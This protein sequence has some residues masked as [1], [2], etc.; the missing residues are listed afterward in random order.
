MTL[1]AAASWP[2]S[3]TRMAASS[4]C[5]RTDECRPLAPVLSAVAIP[6]IGSPTK[7]MSGWPVPR[8][9]VRRIGAQSFEWDRQRG[10]WPRR[11]TARPAGTWPPPG[12]SAGAGPHPRRVHDRGRSRGPGDRRAAAAAGDR[13]AV[14]TS[15]D[16]RA[17]ATPYRWFH[18]S[19]SGIQA[20]REVNQMPDRELMRDGAGWSAPSSG[21]AAWPEP[22]GCT[23]RSGVDA[24]V[25]APPQPTPPIRWT[26][27]RCRDRGD[28]G[29]PEV[30]LELV[31]S[32]QATPTE[33]AKA[34]HKRMETR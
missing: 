10:W 15:F 2:P 31:R 30:L 28:D 26:A 19:P 13:F 5:F 7:S 32:S 33:T 8:R 3:P 18:I 29:Q 16:P 6:S 27:D 1:V 17:L 25:P 14:H 20:W 22:R 4:G 11:R 21:H 24:L 9:K 23:G 12:R 34:A